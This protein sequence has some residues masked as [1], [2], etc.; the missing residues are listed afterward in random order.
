MEKIWIYW[1]GFNPPTLW[2]AIAIEW[3]LREEILYKIIFTPDWFRDDKDYWIDSQSRKEIIKVFYTELKEKHGEKIDLESVFLDE[4]H[5]WISTTKELDEYFEN[6]LWTR[7]YHI[8]GTDVI[9]Q[10]PE[11]TNNPNQFIEKDLKKIFISRPWYEQFDL[12]GYE[13]FLIAPTLDNLDVSS[14]QVREALFASHDN[15]LQLVT[16]WVAEYLQRNKI[17]YSAK[18]ILREWEWINTIWIPH[19]NTWELWEWVERRGTG[20]VVASFVENVSRRSF[21]LVQQFRPLMGKQVIECV[22]GIV[23]WGCTPEQ[24]IA[25]EIRQETWYTAHTSNIHFLYEWPKSAGI[26]TESSLDFY[27]RVYN[28]PW[29]QELEDA[30]VWLTIVESEN[31][32]KDLQKVLASKEKEWVLISPSVWSTLW[33]SIVDWYIDNK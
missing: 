16:P 7:P 11:W 30:E 14:T 10:I 31:T 12:Q 21:V 18:K 25:I 1:W 20:K 29:A 19:P 27:T 26:T 24:A 13:N 6:K 17:K 28:N 33:K 8:L 23:D 2:H 5:S 3:L 32:P 15:L 9:P 4:R 22:G